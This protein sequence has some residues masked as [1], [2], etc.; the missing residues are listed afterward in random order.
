[1]ESGIRMNF[2]VSGYITLRNGY[3]NIEQKGIFKIL[4]SQDTISIFSITC[5]ENSNF[6]TIAILGY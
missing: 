2:R 6:L 5:L 1:M 4:T 3:I